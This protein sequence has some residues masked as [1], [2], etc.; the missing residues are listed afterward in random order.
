MR[1]GLLA[2]WRRG[3]AA[4]GFAAAALLAVP[5]GVAAAIGFG[6]SVSG[7]TEGLDSLANG[8][9]SSQAT[10]ASSREIDTAITAIAGGD[11]A[12]PAPAQGVPGTNPVPGG[13]TDAPGDDGGSD[14]SGTGVAQNPPSGGGAPGL[15]PEVNVPSGNPVG[16]LVQDLNDSLGGLLGGGGN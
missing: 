15:D 10:P 5:V 6:S 3:L 16:D 11:P 2:E 14:D 9:D 7:L 13:G 12:A 1:K 4:R 8:P